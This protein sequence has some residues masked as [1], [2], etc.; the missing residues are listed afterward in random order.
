MTRHIKPM[1]SQTNGYIHGGFRRICLLTSLFLMTAFLACTQ[2]STTARAQSLT[3]NTG[4]VHDLWRGYNSDFYT[5][6]ANGG[7]I[8]ARKS[9]GPVWTSFWEYA[10][11]IEM[12]DDAYRHSLTNYPTRSHSSYVEEINNLC[13]GF[14]DNM[15]PAWKGPNGPYDWSKDTYNDDLMWAVMAFARAYEIT[16]NEN[17][18]TAAEENFNTVW[19]RAQPDGT[20]DGSMGLI[21]A[22]GTKRLD[23]N[24]NFSFVIAGNI[25]NK[26]TGDAT[27]KREA[28]AI[29][30]WAKAN[31]YLYSYA[32]CRN[33]PNYTCSK[34][35]YKNDSELGGPITYKD[36]TYHYGVAI[37]AAV[38]EHD[39]TMA[40]TVTNWLMYNL[41]LDDASPAF[42][43]AGTYDGYNILPNYLAGC[44]Y[45][46]NDD[47]YNGIALRG[48]GFALANGVITNPNT[49]PWAQANLQDAWNHRNSTPVIWADWV[50]TTTAGTQYSWSDSAALTGMLDIPAP[51]GYPQ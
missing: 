34:I 21:Q 27:Y 5:K 47:G 43:Y 19:N 3:W 50:S 14:V 18:L 42:P 15:P 49:L 35:L 30:K 1:G 37:K 28:D 25:L 32:P 11:E 6:G 8:F 13:T 44:K 51:F 17:W 7:Y 4:D 41:T 39:T 23:A 12:A 33:E 36:R 9:G 24:I 26:I 40:Q 38:L 46:C 22:Q 45:S 20:T 31:L 48:V 16:K 2:W 10:E 29:F